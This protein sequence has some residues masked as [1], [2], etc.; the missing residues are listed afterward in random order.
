MRA[1]GGVERFYEWLYRR[2]GR[3]YLAGIVAIDVAVRAADHARHAR[4]PAPL[5]RRDHGGVPAHR[6]VAELAVL[7]GVVS[8]SCRCGRWWRRCAAGC[9]ATAPRTPPRFG[10]PRSDCRSSSCGAPGSRACARG[11][12]GVGV[13]RRRA[14]AALLQRRVPAAGGLVAIGYPRCCT[15]SRRVGARPGAAR[16]SPPSCRRTSRPRAWACRCAGSSSARCR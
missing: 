7:L 8:S 12:A 4:D 15:S 9:T 6:R 2:L 11:R 16:T 13:R 14:G 5:H 10:A 1:T 3:H